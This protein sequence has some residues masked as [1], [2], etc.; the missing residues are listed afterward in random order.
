MESRLEIVDKELMRQLNLAKDNL[1]K[2][3]QSEAYK[4]FDGFLVPNEKYIKE[5]EKDRNEYL[6]DL[7]SAETNNYKNLM[8]EI[9]DFIEF[10]TNEI[11]NLNQFFDEARKRGEIKEQLE[12]LVKNLEVL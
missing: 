10:H 9:I 4:D 3:R 12:W 8:V 7:F 11:K 1:I 5:V 2:A 6:K